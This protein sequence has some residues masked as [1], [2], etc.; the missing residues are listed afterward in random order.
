MSSNVILEVGMLKD[1][2]PL[3]RRRYTDELDND[4]CIIGGL[5]SALEQFTKTT[6]QDIPKEFHMENY[7]TLLH[8]VQFSHSEEYVLI[9]AITR[10]RKEGKNIRKALESVGVKIM[11]WR[12]LILSN[13]DTSAF[14]EVNIVFDDVFTPFNAVSVE[15]MKKR[16][17]RF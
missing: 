9:Y 16:L 4:A 7:T 17:S 5:L 12:K 6:F 3:V 11:K 14:I 15:K 8:R 2:L 1:G 13:I 10:A